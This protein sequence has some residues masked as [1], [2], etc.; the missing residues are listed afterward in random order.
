MYRTANGNKIVY[1]SQYAK[2]GAPMFD[3]RGRN[4]NAPTAIYQL[5]CS[6]NKKYVGKTTNVERRMKQHFT[7]RGSQVT[8]KFAPKSGR[9][10]ATCHGFFADQV[11]QDFT[12]K[13][14]GRYGYC[15]VR[16]GK[17]TNSKTLHPRRR[18]KG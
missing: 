7:G 8:K 9:V 14:I 13:A 3:S 6:H 18:R 16:G 11:E 4:V 10:V 1:P 5:N 12:N 15:N 17:Y 2:T